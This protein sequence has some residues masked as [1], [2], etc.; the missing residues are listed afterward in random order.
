MYVVGKYISYKI[1]VKINYEQGIKE[2]F[3]FMAA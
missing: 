1:L 3:K 2:E